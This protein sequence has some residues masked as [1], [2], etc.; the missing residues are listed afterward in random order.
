MADRIPTGEGFAEAVLAMVDRI[1]AGQ[2][3]TYGDIAALLG[4]RG[5]RVVGQ[6]MAHSGGT[7]PWWRVIR[8]D[9]RPPAA[10]EAEALEHYRAEG[11]PMRGSGLDYRIDLRAC[12]WDPFD[13]G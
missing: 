8:S 6:V 13:E 2:A 11:T 9:G 3:A 5:A 10:H 1:P 7:V 4:S 12:R